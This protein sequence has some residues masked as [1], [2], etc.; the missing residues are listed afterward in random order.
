M[1]RK[2]WIWRWAQAGPGPKFCTLSKI[3]LSSPVASGFSVC[4][5]TGCQQPQIK[6]FQH[7]ESTPPTQEVTGPSRKSCAHLLQLEEWGAL[8]GRPYQ[9][10]MIGEDEFIQRNGCFQK[11]KQPVSTAVQHCKYVDEGFSAPLQNKVPYRISIL[12]LQKLAWGSF[13]LTTSAWLSAFL[14]SSPHFPTCYK[15][16]GTESA[17]LPPGKGELSL[18]V[19]REFPLQ[20]LLKPSDNGPCTL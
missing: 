2:G 18:L 20:S 17:T 7:R 12:P 14:T 19:E 16:P 5:G 11:K 9:N 8:T 3:G 13:H 15:V 6:F 1:E 4:T 10:Y